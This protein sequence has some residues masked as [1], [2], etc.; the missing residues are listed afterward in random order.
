MNQI[1]TKEVKEEKKSQKQ[2]IL[3][4]M[5]EKFPDWVFNTELN[6]IC[7]RY[8]GRLMELRRDGWEIVNE[9]V[10]GTN[11]QVWRCRLLKPF[12]EKIEPV[13]IYQSKQGAL[14]I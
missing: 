1:N 6:D 14:G 13:G 9:P 7:F 4:K 8:G 3:E 11:R 2:I 12:K 10:P 5:L